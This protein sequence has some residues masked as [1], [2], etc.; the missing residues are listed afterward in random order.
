MAELKASKMSFG[1]VY[2][3]TRVSQGF[4]PSGKGNRTLCLEESVKNLI[5]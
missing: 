4:H 2:Y 3:H 1:N 5:N